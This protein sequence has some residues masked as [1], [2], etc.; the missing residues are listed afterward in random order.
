M[1][2]TLAQLN[3]EFES[4]PFIQ[5]SILL[6]L[7]RKHTLLEVHRPLKKKSPVWFPCWTALEGDTLVEF[8]LR[9]KAMVEISD[10]LSLQQGLD[11]G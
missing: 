9:F 1:S 10:V 3:C 2:T 6:F 11:L 4:R 8:T 5:K 7:T